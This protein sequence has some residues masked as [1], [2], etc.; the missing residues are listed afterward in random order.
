MEASQASQ[1]ISSSLLSDVPSTPDDLDFSSSR[2]PE[3][4]DTRFTV[5]RNDTNGPRPRRPRR[6]RRR[7][8]RERLSAQRKLEAVANCLSDM[9]RSLTGFLRAW[10]KN[11]LATAA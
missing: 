6:P 8:R 10:I 4:L 2:E 3:T 9:S 11:H 5:D 1:N 7:N